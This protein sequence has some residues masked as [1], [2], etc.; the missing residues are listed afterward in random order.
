[1]TEDMSSL[2]DKELNYSEGTVMK[3]D[4]L[5]NIENYRRI[6]D[7]MMKKSGRQQKVTLLAATKTV[8]VETI[9]Y[10][11]REGGLTDIGENKVQEL[12]DKYPY[13]EKEGVNI[14]FIG[15]LQ[16]NKVKYIIDKVTMIQS[17]DSLPLAREIDR[18]AK[19]L[20]RC[21][22]VLIEI[23][24]GREENKGGIMPEEIWNFIDDIAPLEGI[25]IKG[26]MTMAPNCSKK[27]DYIKYFEETYKIFIDILTK[28]P[29]N[30]DVS[31]LSM[32]MSQSVEPAVLCGS[33]MVRVGSG[34]FGAR[35]NPLKT[36]TD[37]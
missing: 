24:I 26:M 6:I 13:L 14:H 34:I 37:K 32:G 27:E 25:C 11:I 18:R 16:T 20:G 33:N 30:I 22:D 4:I 15:H 35:P 36:N 2:Q 19:K 17:L 10:A 23:N 5:Q 8:D 29:H 12:V 21:M 1:M 3:N 28:K 31:I 7:E 9:N